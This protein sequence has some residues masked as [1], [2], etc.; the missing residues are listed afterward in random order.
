MRGRPHGFRVQREPP[1]PHSGADAPGCVG[2]HGRGA[3]HTIPSVSRPPDQ[4]RL[5]LERPAQATFLCVP[6]PFPSRPPAL[7]GQIL[8]PLGALQMSPPTAIWE[9]GIRSFSEQPREVASGL[10]LRQQPLSGAFLRRSWGRTSF[11]SS[12]TRV[13]WRRAAECCVGQLELTC[14][15][16][17]EQSCHPHLHPLLG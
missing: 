14:T 13:I 1:S 12:H 8:G 6:P 11:S 5:W 4:G 17:K 2:S 9:T 7:S 3:A 10:P 15:L 16:F